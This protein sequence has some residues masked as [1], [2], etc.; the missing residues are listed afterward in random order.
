MHKI[1]VRKRSDRGFFMHIAHINFFA[2]KTPLLPQN[3]VNSKFS[4]LVKSS[5][6]PELMQG[7]IR[8]TLYYSSLLEPLS[9]PQKV[10]VLLDCISKFCPAHAYNSEAVSRRYDVGAWY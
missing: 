7:N 2:L 4:F 6:C 1:P 5:V 3:S 8:N 9:A 10:T